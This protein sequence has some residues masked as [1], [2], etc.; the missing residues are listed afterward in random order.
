M[1]HGKKGQQELIG[2]YN[3]YGRRNKFDH[4][5]NLVHKNK[6]SSEYLG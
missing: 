4:S 3:N 5:I 1:A 6:I 2:R